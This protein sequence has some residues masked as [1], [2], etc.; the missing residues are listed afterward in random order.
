[1]LPASQ[2]ST[3]CCSKAERLSL[4][5]CADDQRDIAD[6]FARTGREPVEHLDLIET[7]DGPS[8]SPIFK[9]SLAYI[10][11]ELHS[12]YDGGDHSLVVGAVK[13]V[14]SDEGG[15][16]LVYFNRNYRGIRDL[17]GR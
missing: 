4:T 9:P 16:P 7:F 8:G 14:D 2:R 10:D 15:R 6:A 13:A 17:D 1:M 3:T 11:C 5:F 12:I